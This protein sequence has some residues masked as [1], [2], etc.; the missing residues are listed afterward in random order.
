MVAII[1]KAN[2]TRNLSSWT[3]A[4]GSL[5]RKVS[6]MVYDVIKAKHNLP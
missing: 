4:R 2:R 1:E 6:A 5:I 3:G